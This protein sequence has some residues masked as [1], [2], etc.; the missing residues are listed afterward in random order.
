MQ[1]AKQLFKLLQ[2]KNTVHQL[3]ENNNPQ[4]T[5]NPQHPILNAFAGEIAHAE[6]GERTKSQ[7]MHDGKRRSQPKL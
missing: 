1:A 7:T 4:T 3:W 5:M 6:N 2:G